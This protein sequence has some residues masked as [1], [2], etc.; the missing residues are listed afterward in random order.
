MTARRVSFVDAQAGSPVRVEVRLVN[1]DADRT[2]VEARHLTGVGGILF[3]GPCRQPSRSAAWPEAGSVECRD[4]A[5]CVTYVDASRPDVD[6]VVGRW[7]ECPGFVAAFSPPR[8]A[9]DAERRP[10]AAA[11]SPYAAHVAP[12]QI[13]PAV[14][15][16]THGKLGAGGYAIAFEEASQMRLDSLGGDPEIGSDFVIG[17]AIYDAAHDR[18]LAFCQR[19]PTRC[20]PFQKLSRRERWSARHHPANGRDDL[21]RLCRLK[22]VAARAEAHRDFE[23]F[24]LREAREN[25]ERGS[26]RVCDAAQ[27]LG[28]RAIREAEIDQHHV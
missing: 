23:I 21:S 7:A 15:F 4:Q 25:D 5:P 26:A 11:A 20:V 10:V 8:S 12:R 17:P 3:T 6:P 9:T 18:R 22:K 13:K 27:Q 16:S 24:R 1:G 2:R 28:P 19:L 14:S